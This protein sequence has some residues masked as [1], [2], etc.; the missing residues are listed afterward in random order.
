MNDCLTNPPTE[1]GSYNVA[2][3]GIMSCAA[4]YWD[5]DGTKWVDTTPY[6]RELKEGTAK[7]W[8]NK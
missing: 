7:W 6:V 4:I 5:F 2:I 8:P 1:P 3:R